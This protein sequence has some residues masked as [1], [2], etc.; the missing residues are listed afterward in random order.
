VPCRL[1]GGTRARMACS[2]HALA[3]C[4]PVL[5]LQKWYHNDWVK[6]S[7]RKQQL[8][9][10]YIWPSQSFNR[11]A[12][13]ITVAYWKLGRL[14]PMQLHRAQPLGGR[15]GPDPP[16]FAWT[17]PTIFLGVQFWWVLYSD[18]DGDMHFKVNC[19]HWLKVAFFSNWLNWVCGCRAS[20]WSCFSFICCI[21]FT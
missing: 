3:H 10:L 2:L 5:L 12:C 6:E 20:I 11:A 21:S 13:W 4:Q 17:P 16:T 19:C 1:G 8:Y 7:F 18:D 9:F 15:E 14:I